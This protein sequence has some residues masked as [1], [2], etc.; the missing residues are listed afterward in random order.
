MD[1]EENRKLRELSDTLKREIDE[2][3]EL[4]SNLRDVR[5]VLS[6]LKLMIAG[7][8]AL[9]AGFLIYGTGGG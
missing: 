7:S 2:T 9:I 5:V 8:M 3:R 4:N 1:H 6:L